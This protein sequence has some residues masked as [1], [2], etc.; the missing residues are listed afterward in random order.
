MRK[1]NKAALLRITPVIK[2]VHQRAVSPPSQQRMSQ[3]LALRGTIDAR[4]AFLALSKDLTQIF[5]ELV[6]ISADTQQRRACQNTQ[7]TKCLSQVRGNTEVTMAPQ[8][9]AGCTTIQAAAHW[10]VGAGVYQP[11]AQRCPMLPSC[12]QQSEQPACRG[13]SLHR[14]AALNRTRTQSRSSGTASLW[15]PVAEVRT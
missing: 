5:L 14:A 2:K 3:E 1:F 9:P 8:L 11:W 12:Q 15:L 10:G 7:K 6:I 4:G 13:E